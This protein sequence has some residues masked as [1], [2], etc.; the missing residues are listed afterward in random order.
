MNSRKSVNFKIVPIF[1]QAAANVWNDFIKIEVACDKATYD[2]DAPSQSVIQTK[3]R[4][5]KRNLYDYKH[6][7][8]FVAYYRKHIIGF[9]Q[10]F[11]IS[12]YEMYLNRLYVLP[13]YQHYGI[14]SRLLHIT[15]QSATIYAKKISMVA[16]AN[17][18]DFY[19]QKHGYSQFEYMEK[20]LS[21][22][23][24]CIVPVFQWVKKDFHV[25]I[26]VPVDT[27]VL[28]QSKYQPIF[29]HINDDYEVDAVTTRTNNGTN[30]IWVTQQS[31]QYRAELLKALTKTK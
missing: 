9:A 15:E 8:A 25:K 5:F 28:K 23:S 6:N 10:G 26:D 4:E 3:L 11:S 31:K 19:E 1:N 22:I 20:E 14:G 29:A 27:M 16:L 2:L 12:P 21:P 30:K 13:Q 24:N 18:V 17:A 7:F